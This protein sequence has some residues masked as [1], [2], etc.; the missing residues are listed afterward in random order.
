MTSDGM[1]SDLEYYVQDVVR[2][3]REAA[4]DA[5]ENTR[6]AD[7]AAGFHGGRALAYAE[8]LSL[9]QSL[10]DTFLIPRARL[11]LDGFDPVADLSELRIP[12]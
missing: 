10:A 1:H 3:L 5:R 9:M 11:G 6:K 8:V 4:N 7:E 12:K 2:L